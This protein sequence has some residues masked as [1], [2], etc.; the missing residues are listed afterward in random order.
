MSECFYC[1]LCNYCSQLSKEP[2]IFFFPF[3]L[4]FSFRL[5]ECF[6]TG[7]RL[8]TSSYHAFKKKQTKKLNN[9]VRGIRRLMNTVNYFPF[10]LIFFFLL[11]K[12]NLL[13]YH[14]S[15][16]VYRYRGFDRYFAVRILLFNCSFI[17]FSSAR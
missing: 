14:R 15:L 6:A 11:L 17:N 13:I 2:T 4:F 7:S 12:S 5:V 1:S 8:S 16:F 3:I 9:R 10:F